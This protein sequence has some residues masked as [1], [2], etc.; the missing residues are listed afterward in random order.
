MKDPE[1]EDAAWINIPEEYLIQYDKNL[2]E[3]ISDAMH[4][5]FKNNYDN[6]NYNKNWAIVTPRNKITEK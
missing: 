5:D 3:H 2:I 1:N 4:D 6:I